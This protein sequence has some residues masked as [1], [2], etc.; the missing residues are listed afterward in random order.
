MRNYCQV[1]TLT[2]RGLDPVMNLS[3]DISVEAQTTLLLSTRPGLVK[4]I[5]GSRSVTTDGLTHA[6]V[7]L[8]CEVL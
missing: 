8:V 1:I 3:Y 2:M 5:S 7:Q 4:G 6:S